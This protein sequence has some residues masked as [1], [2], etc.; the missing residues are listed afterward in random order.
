LRNNSN[1]N[2]EISSE[3]R[4]ASCAKRTG[5]K[6]NPTIAR[7]NAAK[8]VA[9]GCLVDEADIR[10]MNIEMTQR[11]KKRS[12]YKPATGINRRAGARDYAPR[13]ESTLITDVEFEINLH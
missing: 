5:I 13:R 10:P 2:R 11:D 7:R 9:A 3:F 6:W 4:A 8:E 1:E 12:R